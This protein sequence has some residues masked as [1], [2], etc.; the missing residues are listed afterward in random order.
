MVPLSMRSR[1][2]IWVVL[3]LLCVTGLWL[4]WHAESRQ[5]HAN[6]HALGKPA[7]VSM[8]TTSSAPALAP[9][10]LSHAA[11][12]LAASKTNRLAY[13]LSNTD[14]TLE[15]VM[16]DRHG[17]LR[18]NALTDVGKPINLPCPKQLQAKG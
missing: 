6:L 5:P 8:R 12:L 16:H 15:E 9:K 18:E 3:S 13:R 4:I 10:A 1:R 7:F 11:T 14:K 17:I 2:A